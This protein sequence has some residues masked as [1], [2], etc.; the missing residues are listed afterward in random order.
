MAFLSVENMLKSKKPNPPIKGQTQ[1]SKVL[2]RYSALTNQHGVK[3]TRKIIILALAAVLIIVIT[4]GY[5][6]WTYYTSQNQ[7]N[8]AP[9]PSVEQIRDQTMVY[10]EANHTE[11]MQVMQNLNWTGGRQETG[12][13]GAETYLYTSGNWSLTIQYPVVVNPTYTITANYS[14]QTVTVDWSGT[15]NGT[16]TETSQTISVLSA[17]LTQEQVR[18]ITMAY[19]KAN[20]NETAP[21]ML[22]LL[23]TGGRATPEGILGAETYSYQSSS[24][25]VTIQYPVVPNPTYTVT[26]KYT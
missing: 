8:K 4:G 5:L 26:A 1:L 2:Y 12:L 11:T 21:Y 13:L 18:D 22:S 23:W 19:I 6:G 7:N 25:I 17:P 20:H 10:I 15:Y 3:N 14:S 16:L 24:W 9:S